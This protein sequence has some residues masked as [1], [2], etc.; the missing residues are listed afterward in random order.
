MLEAAMWEAALVMIIGVWVGAITTIA[1]ERIPVWRR[2]DPA[3]LHA[4][5]TWLHL[6]RTVVAIVSPG[7]FVTATLT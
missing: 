7:L 6:V 3:S 4:R 2:L 1:R 5:W